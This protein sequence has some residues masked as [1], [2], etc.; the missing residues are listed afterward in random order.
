MRKT[1]NAETMNETKYHF[2][3]PETNEINCAGDT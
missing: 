1:L 2:Q 3:F